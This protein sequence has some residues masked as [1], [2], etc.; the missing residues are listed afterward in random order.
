[1]TGALMVPL[2][3][4]EGTCR[5]LAIL[6]GLA[7]VPLLYARLAPESIPGLAERGVGSLPWPGMG[8]LL[9]YT[10]LLVYGWHLLERGAEPGP[11]VHFDDERLAEVSGSARFEPRDDPFPYYLG[12]AAGGD[13]AETASL[14]SMA[15]AP[16]V[17]GF[18]GPINLLIALDA[19]GTLRGVRYLDS[20][21]T[22]SYIM[23]IDQWLSGLTGQDLAAGPLD[24][25]RVDALTGATVSSKAALEAINRS[26]GRATEAAF[27]RPMPAAAAAPASR[28]DLGF[29][30]TLS[31]LLAFFP[32]YLSGSERARLIFQLAALGVLGVWLNT[33]VTEVD[34]VNLSLGHAAS[35]AE[36]PQRWLLLGF[37]AVTG[38]LFGQVWCG[39]VCPFGALQEIAS[40]LG[41]RLGL[42]TY[43]ERGLEQRMRWLKHLLLA[44]MLI[45][46]WVSGET[47]WASFDPMQH[48]FGGRLSDWML[49]LAA[50]VLLGSLFYVRFWCRYFCPLGA[51][52]SLTNKIALLE[53]FAPR[54]R[55]EHCDLGVH[56][57]FDLDCIRCS[58]CLTGADTTV[59]RLVRRESPASSRQPPD[60]V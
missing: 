5:V 2:L 39:Y 9:V 50:V 15:A 30:A 10:V 51:L 4:V 56:H 23:G 37:V 34:L 1:M 40:R 59:R 16:E 11:L 6:A 18:A 7:L 24:L 8:W 12:R 52:L 28:L 20:N 3:G 42:R 33:L 35:P 36:N 46:V 58:R 47:L 27:G 45:A 19:K 43:P 55:F 49:T 44:V 57:E 31:L 53:R 54:R 22:P 60:R 41:R 17:K 13:A 26:A 38:L 25:T 32:V 29:Y 21:E 48:V 14:A